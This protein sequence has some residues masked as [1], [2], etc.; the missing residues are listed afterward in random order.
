MI[1]RYKEI[2]AGKM[3]VGQVA[4]SG[5][6]VII[7]DVTQALAVDDFVAESGCASLVAIPLISKGRVLGTLSGTNHVPRTYSQQHLDLLDSMCSHL[8]VSIENANLFTRTR[9][10]VEQLREAERFKAVFFSNISHE[11]RTPLTSIIGY[12]ETLLAQTAGELTPSQREAVT[13]IQN[14]GTMLVDII[15]NLLDLS[16]IRAGKM[17]LHFGE[18]SMA[19]LIATCL[20]AMDPLASQKAQVLSHTLGDERLMIQAD[21]IKVK[22]ILLNL[23]SN[24]I[25]FTPH[26]GRIVVEAREALL[27][28]QPAIEVSV[29]DQGIGISPDDLDKIFDEFTQV[30]S[31]YTR[32]YAGSGLGLPIVKQFVEMHGGRVTVKS[33]PGKGSRFS[34]VLPRRLEAEPAPIATEADQTS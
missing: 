22:Q 7:E 31:S 29:A 10:M 25:K 5:Q 13:N 3:L 1:K 21:Q 32:A 14:S 34:V 20:K 24:A 18:F 9:A 30:D 19:H 15:S 11:L 16:K 27:D 2:A 23:L 8:S 12:S 26:G 28:E 33:Q 6:R 4:S 17:E